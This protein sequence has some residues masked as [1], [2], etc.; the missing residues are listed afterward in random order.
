MDLTSIY[1]ENIL[2]D[3]NNLNTFFKIKKKGD[4]DDFILLERKLKLEINVIKM[5]LF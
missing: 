3:I 1:N 5:V 4:I 2:I